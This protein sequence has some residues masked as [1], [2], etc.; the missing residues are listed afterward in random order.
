MN[1]NLG[2]VFVY[3]ASALSDKCSVQ[4]MICAKMAKYI[5]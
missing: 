1:F 5:I 3:T 2:K 4:Y